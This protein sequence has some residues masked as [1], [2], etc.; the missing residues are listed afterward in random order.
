MNFIYKQSLY[1]MIYI[2]L[3]SRSLTDYIV[4][5]MIILKLTKHFN[6]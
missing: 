4:T 5:V 3:C 2:K 1:E 6:L